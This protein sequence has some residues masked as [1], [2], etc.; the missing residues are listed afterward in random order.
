MVG[1]LIEAHL[2]GSMKEDEECDYYHT[3][4]DDSS[5]QVDNKLKKITVLEKTFQDVVIE[6]QVM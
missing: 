2:S 6:P 5:P 3:L 1:S 4:I